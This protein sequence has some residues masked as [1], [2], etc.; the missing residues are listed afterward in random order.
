MERFWKMLAGHE[1]PKMWE[2]EIKVKSSWRPNPGNLG[3]APLRWAIH[4]AQRHE[5]GE[6]EEEKVKKPITP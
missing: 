5:E 3:T 4:G 6:T 2:L 1:E